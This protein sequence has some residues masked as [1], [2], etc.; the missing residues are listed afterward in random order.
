MRSGVRRSENIRP[1]RAV[2]HHSSAWFLFKFESLLLLTSLLGPYLTE[3][4]YGVPEVSLANGTDIARLAA[5]L[6]AGP[7]AITLGETTG[8]DS[9]KTELLM[10]KLQI[11]RVLCMCLLVCE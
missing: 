9:R 3:K 1:E 8:S 6:T 2:K 7:H 5:L 10:Q 11:A 4:G